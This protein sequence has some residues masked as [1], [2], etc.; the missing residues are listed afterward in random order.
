MGTAEAAE[1]PEWVPVAGIRTAKPGPYFDAVRIAGERGSE[2]AAALCEAAGGNPGPILQQDLGTEATL[3]L[4]P[5]RPD[6]A[7]RWPPGIRELSA[8]DTVRIPAYGHADETI[9][10]LS[11]PTPKA[12]FVDRDALR[13]LLI[14]MTGWAPTE[15]P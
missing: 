7:F 14:R 10:W 5:P 8:E 13:A 15:E 9:T 11:R 2:T 4:V 1:R 12:P 6:T 3:F